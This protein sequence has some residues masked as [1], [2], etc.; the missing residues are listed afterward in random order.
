MKWILFG[1]MVATS[2]ALG[3]DY[4][5]VSLRSYH[6]VRKGQNE[7]NLGLA[8]EWKYSERV[9]GSA[10]FYDNSSN[11]FSAYAAAVYSPVRLAPGVRLGVMGGLVTGYERKPWQP[12]PLGGLV[13][14]A[15][16]ARHGVNLTLLPA[17]GGIFHLAYK[18]SFM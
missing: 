4:L 6:V 18:R 15:E 11:N 13:L 7:L 2:E 5:A 17:A 10:G 1:L 12:I 16:N 3:C 9:R 8:C 14:S